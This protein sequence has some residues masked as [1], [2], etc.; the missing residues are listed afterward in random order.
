MND[1]VL[2]ICIYVTDVVDTVCTDLHYFRNLISVVHLGP[3]RRCANYI[4]YFTVELTLQSAQADM[5]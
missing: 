5:L 2:Q 4:S 1:G 3:Y